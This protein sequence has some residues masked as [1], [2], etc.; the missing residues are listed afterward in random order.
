MGWAA[1]ARDFKSPIMRMKG[2]LNAE[3]YQQMV[4]ESGVIQH[5]NGR[6]GRN[7]WMFQQDGASPHQATTRKEFL[8]AQ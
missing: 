1:I 5:T 6:Y 8:A 2:R 4:W 7:A 3:G